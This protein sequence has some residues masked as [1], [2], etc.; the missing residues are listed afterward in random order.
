MG[1]KSR[2]VAWEAGQVDVQEVL[3][4]DLPLGRSG[5]EERRRTGEALLARRA[6]ASAFEAEDLVPGAPNWPPSQ[7]G[8][9]VGEYQGPACCE[10]EAGAQVLRPSTFGRR[11]G[12]RSRKDS[13]SLRTV[14]DMFPRRGGLQNDPFGDGWLE[15]LFC[16]M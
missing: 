8:K 4:F 1:V 10:K 9:T 5:V 11:M 3:A 14:L 12:R 7:A 16:R 6:S 13:V 15:H 2:E